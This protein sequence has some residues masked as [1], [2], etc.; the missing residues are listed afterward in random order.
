MKLS[1]IIQELL[2]GSAPNFFRSQVDY[3]KEFVCLML[4]SMKYVY[5]AHHTGLSSL[6]YRNTIIS[7]SKEIQSSATVNK[8]VFTSAPSTNMP[9]SPVYL[10][11]LEDKSNIK[12]LGH[13]ALNLVLSQI[14]LNLEWT[15][16]MCNQLCVK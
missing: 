3:R 8:I 2:L 9:L 13:S 7:S 12:E 1:S 15:L 10:R 4:E 11:V 5:K 6:W 14:I 16:M